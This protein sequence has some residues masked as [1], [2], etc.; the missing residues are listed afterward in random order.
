MNLPAAFRSSSLSTFGLLMAL[1]AGCSALR[2]QGKEAVTAPAPAADEAKVRAVLAD[3]YERQR[4]GMMNVSPTD[5]EFLRILA[6]STKAKR[7]L[8]IG[9]SNGY[10]GIWISLG[11]CEN[12]GKLLT[13]EKDA[14]RA[15][16]ARANIKR[17][18][19]EGVMQLIE[20]DALA[21]I[22]E[23]EGPAGSM[24]GPLCRPS[25]KLLSGVYFRVSFTKWPPLRS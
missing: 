22:P 18:G 15:S 23:I 4:Q 16:L 14:G 24:R 9:T 17:A 7:A 20:G 1:A 25:S 5:G 10:S 12:G 11:L 6:A 2:P 13:L 8:E 19:F 21:K 3:M